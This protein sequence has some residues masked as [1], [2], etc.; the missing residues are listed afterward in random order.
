MSLR[1]PFVTTSPRARNLPLLLVLLGAFALRVVALDQLG[2]A[3]DESASALMARA[4]PQAIVDFHWRAAFE[5]PP[6]WVLLLHGW[7]RVVGQSEFALRLLPALAGC[8]VVAMSWRLART[9]WPNEPRLPGISALFCALAPVLV[10][11]SQEA[12]MYTLVVLLMLMATYLALRLRIQPRRVDLVTFWLVSWLMLGLHY[13]AV[14]ALAIQAVIISIEGLMYGPRRV[15]WL[16]LIVAYGGAVIP[17]LLWMLFSPGFH[18][19]LGVVLEKAGEN[20][21]TWHYFLGDLWRELAFG[22]IRWQPTYATWGY[23]IA[24]LVVVGAIQI[25]F[26]QQ[27]DALTRVAAWTTVAVVLLPILIGT[28]ALRTLVPRY[29]L[30]IVPLFYILAALPAARLWQRHWLAGAAMTLFVVAIN[31]LALQYYL[32]PYRKSDYRAMTAYL[33][34]HGDPASEMLLLEAPRQH[35]LAKYYVEDTWQMHP[36]PTLPLPKYWPVTAPPLVPED[37]DDRIQAWL[38]AQQGLWVSYTSEAEVDRGEFLAK[39][40]TAVAYRDHC[41]QWL[42]VRLCHYISP[43]HLLPISVSTEP[44]LFGNELALTGTH[45]AL[46]RHATLPDS[47]LVQLDWYAQAKPTTDYKVALRLLTAEGEI[48]DEANDFPIGPL[49]PPSTWQAED[50]KPGYVTL[51]LPPQVEL[52]RYRL[53]VALYDPNTLANISHMHVGATFP[54]GEDATPTAAPFTLAELSI[55][56]TVEIQ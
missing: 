25:F 31:V 20:P 56:D 16:T 55:G 21:V 2:L 41:T 28:I 49:L 50:R 32:G 24:P 19:T 53:Q 10:Y 34:A 12:R 3:Y 39:Y 14:V 6:L 17:V 1:F 51:R 43:H 8:A 37:E 38:A 23:A 46:Y 9:L 27:Q 22:S 42:D 29:I 54:A 11:Y 18:T 33:H 7:S 40:L 47:L 36:M 52:G 35:L 15:P 45:V 26:R 44:R 48:V 30:W 13:Y 5:H 4:T